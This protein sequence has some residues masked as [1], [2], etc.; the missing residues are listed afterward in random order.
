MISW[1]ELNL[2]LPEKEEA[3]K[4]A[5]IFNI[6][7]FSIH[8]GPGIRTVIFFKGCPLRC[9]WCANPESQ[10]PGPE[11]E[12]L[13]GNC[14]G[15]GECMKA[16][17][18]QAI[19]VQR[20]GIQINRNRCR[21]CGLCAEQCYSNTLKYIGEEMTVEEVVAEIKKDAVFYQNSGGGFTFSGG[22][23]LSCADF[24]LDVLRACRPMGYHSAIETSGYGSREAFVEMAKELSLIFLDI[25]HSDPEVHKKLT[26]VSNECIL[27]NLRSIEP[28]ASEIIVR[29]PLVPG[30]NDS[31]EN[32]LATARIC[33]GNA[34][35]KEWEILPFHNLGEHKYEALGKEYDKAMFSK[36]GREH[37]E[38]LADLANRVLKPAGKQCRLGGN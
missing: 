26:G 16:C 2:V 32:I 10:L 11:L 22:E 14:I 13:P 36:P 31:R 34:A 30:L 27:E 15:C 35:V 17:P 37:M 8:D 9:L 23:P 18:N 5:A 38:A 1:V 6:Q 24:C 4:K 33:A 29:T 25:K 21:R 28:Y 19:S 3:M 7:R 20:E 12:V